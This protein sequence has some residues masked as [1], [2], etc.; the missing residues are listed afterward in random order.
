MLELTVKLKPWL[1]RSQRASGFE[2]LEWPLEERDKFYLL[3]SCK[4]CYLCRAACP[5]AEVS[6]KKPEITR[7]PGAKFYVRD[8]PT[9]FLDPREED[10]QQRALQL[11][12]DIDAYA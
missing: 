11:K 3:T 7:Y 12:E 5:A 2:K 1:V 6:F 10:K 9:R 8:L 4:E